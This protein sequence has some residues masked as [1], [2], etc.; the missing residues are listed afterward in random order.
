MAVGQRQKPTSPPRKRACGA[1]TIKPRLCSPPVPQL[2]LVLLGHA[3]SLKLLFRIVRNRFA[4]VLLSSEPFF[5]F[6]RLLFLGSP[7]HGGGPRT[8]A[9]Q[10]QRFTSYR[11]TCFLMQKAYY[12][13]KELPLPSSDEQVIPSRNRSRLSLVYCEQWVI[14]ISCVPM[15]SVDNYM[16]VGL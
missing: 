15:Q 7:P 5:A 3:V 12:V 10:V 14:F 8:S 2:L 6:L 11:S 13:L 16:L 1:N 4:P 9:A